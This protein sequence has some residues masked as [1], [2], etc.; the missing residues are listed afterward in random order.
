MSTDNQFYKEW[1]KMSKGEANRHIKPS[2]LERIDPPRKEIRDKKTVKLAGEDKTKK[3]AKNSKKDD[4]EDN[5]R[6]EI[7]NQIIEK[8]PPKKYIIT[9]LQKRINGEL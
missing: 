3:S 7:L 8:K 4:S 9:Y 2:T 1:L 5:E 6:E